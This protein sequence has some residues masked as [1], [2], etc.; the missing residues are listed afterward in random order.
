MT[1]TIRDF[2]LEGQL[3]KAS[4]LKMDTTCDGVH[5]TKLKLMVDTRVDI[6]M[7]PLSVDPYTMMSR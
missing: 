4:T 1:G 2:R 3:N 6:T 7:D 5:Y